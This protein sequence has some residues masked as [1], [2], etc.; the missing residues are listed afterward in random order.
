MHISVGGEA[1]SEQAGLFMITN[2]ITTALNMGNSFSFD[3]PGLGDRF[4]SGEL[5]G[6]SF[7]TGQVAYGPADNSDPTLTVSNGPEATAYAEALK[8][9]GFDFIKTYWQLPASAIGRFQT[10]SARLDLPLI[11]HIPH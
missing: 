10:E 4:E 3:I 11:G 1:A 7:Y 8:N 5:I 9:Q 2:G 6:P